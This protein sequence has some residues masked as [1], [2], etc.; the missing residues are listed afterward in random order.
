MHSRT[1]NNRSNLSSTSGTENDMYDFLTYTH[2]RT[3]EQAFGPGHRD[4]IVSE[5]DDAPI[6]YKDKIVL[7]ASAAAAVALAVILVAA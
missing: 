1:Y 7:W 6:D 5:F 2:P 3:M 4:P